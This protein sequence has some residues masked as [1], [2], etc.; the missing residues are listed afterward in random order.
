VALGRARLEMDDSAAAISALER[1]L[2]LDATNLVANKLLVE[3]YLTRGD[4]QSARER[5]DLYGLLN[6]SDPEI[7]RLRRRVDGARGEGGAGD[8]PAEVTTSPAE[9]AAPETPAEQATGPAAADGVVGMEGPTTTGFVAPTWELEGD[10]G[11]PAAPRGDTPSRAPAGAAR[12]DGPPF[13]DLAAGGALRRY[14]EGLGREGLFPVALAEEPAPV[15]AAPEEPAE[16]AAAAVPAAP[17]AP[18]EADAGPAADGAPPAGE[19]APPVAAASDADDRPTVTLGQ[20]YLEQ[21]H[22]AKAR[23]IF[24]AVLGTEP[25][26]AAAREGLARA[27]RELAALGSQP[28][29]AADLL[30]DAD[31]EEPAR[32]ALLLAYLRRIRRHDE[33]RHADVP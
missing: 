5:L 30:E 1:A 29:T 3:A 12:R 32:R 24:A 4:R 10:D 7:P 20:L 22:A 28:L 18:V 8:D 6:D 14:L 27:E 26:D 31:R 21:G 17:P 13:G 2:E 15:A 19:V 23:R 33:S 11:T 16:P 25:A 9:P